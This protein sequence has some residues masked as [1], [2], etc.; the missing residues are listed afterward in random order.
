LNRFDKH[1]ESFKR[2]QNDPSDTTSIIPGNIWHIIEDKNHNVW[3]ATTRGFSMYNRESETF[4]NYRITRSG[5]SAIKSSYAIYSLYPDKDDYLWV[6]SDDGVYRFHTPSENIKKIYEDESKFIWDIFI[7]RSERCWFISQN[8]LLL[9][10]IR[11]QALEPFILRPDKSE[12][13]N[14]QQIRS[15]LE[16]GPGNIW[17]RTLDAIYCYNQDLELKYCLE[18]THPYPLNYSNQ[19]LTKEMFVDNT[20][21]IWFYSPDGINQIIHKRENFRSYVPDTTSFDLGVRCIHLENKNLIWFGTNTGISSFDRTNNIIQLHYGIQGWES[22]FPHAVNTMYLDSENTLWIGMIYEGLLSMVISED[23][24]RRFRKHLPESIDSTRL[25]QYGLYNI[26]NIFEDSRGRLWIGVYPERFLQYYDRK[27]NKL[28]RLVDNPAAKFKLPERAMIRHQTGSDT[29]W[30]IGSS[31]VYKI[32]LPFTKIAEDLVMPENVIKCELIDH[33]GQHSNFSEW[34]NESYKDSTGNIWLGTNQHLLKISEN[35]MQGEDDNE[36]RIKY[37]TVNQGLSSNNVQ[38]ILPDDKDNLWIGTDY[39]LSKFN[40]RSETFTNYFIRHGLP[41]NTFWSGSSDIG[42]DG[43]MFFGCHAG[44]ISFYPDSISVNQHVAPV[45]ITDIRINNQLL[46]PGKSDVLKNA[47]NFANKIELRHNQNN[48]SFGYAILNYYQPELNQYKYKL[49]GFNDDWIFAGNKAIVDFTNLDPGKYTFRVAGSNNDGVWN[50]EGASL[51]IIIRHPPWQTWYA[52]L[53]YGLLLAGIILWYRRF[54]IN[55]AKLRLAVE[56]EKVEKQKVQ[57]IDQMKSRFFANVSH[58]FR[59]PLT[60]ILGPLEKT[61]NNKSGNISFSRDLVSAMRR[62]ARRL[63]LLINQILEISKLETGKI[64]LQ[65]SRGDLVGFVRKIVLSFLSLAESK[66]I[67]YTYEFPETSG[68]FYFDPEKLDKILINLI[69]NAFKFTP[70]GGEVKIGYKYIIPDG[71]D[72]PVW[73]EISVSDTGEGIPNEHLDRIFNRFYQVSDSAQLD[74]I[75]TGIGLALTKEL[76]EIYRGEISVESRVG[77]GSTFKVKLPVSK[78]KFLEDEIGDPFKDEKYPKLTG[79]EMTP[80]DEQETDSVKDPEYLKDKPVLLVVEDNPD[81]VNYIS[82]ILADQYWIL[83]AGNG[84]LGFE[85]AIDRIPDLVITDLMMPE[86]DGVEMC[87]K[88]KED[89]RTNHIPVIMLTAKADRD[90]KL[91]GLKTGADD[92]LIKPFDSEELQVRTQNLIEQRK[93]LKA[94]F[95]EEFRIIS[96]DQNPEV[97]EDRLLNRIL[98]I[99]KENISNSEYNV[100]NIGEELYMSRA[101]VFRKIGALT[102][103]SPG[104]LLRVMRLKKAAELLLAGNLNI[105]QVMYEVGYQTPAYFARRFREYYGMNPSEFQRSNKA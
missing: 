58:E 38:S 3:I 20:G 94:A 43:E 71:I 73:V 62:N 25:D 64:S 59:T 74:N 31:G 24:Q 98:D 33:S 27:D 19:W 103:S 42:K 28:F 85:I 49:E 12:R 84:N 9:Y 17:I 90:S 83:T 22:G 53:V 32:I 11:Q 102:G 45:R 101:Q 39:G 65:V 48:L 97:Q 36:C 100:E 63:L 87:R 77:T 79:T 75:G 13:I 21:S 68:E 40:I 51:Q 88:M 47:I 54:M 26:K 2:F 56:I 50:E 70:E 67:E 15:M 95:M 35:G 78:D 105:A 34:V 18:H 89:E 37:Y 7:D 57:E 93:R 6:C 80:H 86:M 96:L 81:M 23:G 66:N 44:M 14:N 4:T 46:Q 104:D 61:D 8:G 72:Y 99:L 5:K 55:R 60:L 69:S 82:G 16:D 29:L 92:Y 1:T 30:A 91:E 41:S 10:D 76:V 52:Y